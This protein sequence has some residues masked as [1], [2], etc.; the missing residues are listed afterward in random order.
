MGSICGMNYSTIDNCSIDGSV[1]VTCPTT[2][3][4]TYYKTTLETWCFFGNATGYNSYGKISNI[5]CN[6]T[7][8]ATMDCR[9]LEGYA[10]STAILTTYIGG[11]IGRND[12]GTITSCSSKRSDDIVKSTTTTKSRDSASINIF[13]TDRI[14]Y[15]YNKNITVIE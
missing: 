12:N 10:K 4:T 8:S 5:T 6:S 13:N 15:P 14:C 7:T 3:L 11:F 9:A 2:N 1:K